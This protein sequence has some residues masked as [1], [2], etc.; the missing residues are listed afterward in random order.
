MKNGSKSISANEINKFTYCPYQWYYERLYGAAY[1]RELYKERNKI[2]GLRDTAFSNFRKGQNFHSKYGEESQP[3][4]MFRRVAIV[5]IIIA[6]II[7]GYMYY[8][9]FL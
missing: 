5:I 4:G 6:A 3:G 7:A 9:N 8:Q 2:L 1:I